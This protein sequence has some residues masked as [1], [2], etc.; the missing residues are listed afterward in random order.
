MVQVFGKYVVSSDLDPYYSL[1]VF[2]SL[3]FCA[4]ELCRKVRDVG[5]R[6][7]G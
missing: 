7:L 3:S 5:S 1:I 2:W 4:V 6:A